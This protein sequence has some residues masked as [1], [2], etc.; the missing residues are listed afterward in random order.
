MDNFRVTRARE[1]LSITEFELLEIAK[2]TGFTSYNSF[3]KTF[4]NI[5]KQTPSQYRHEQRQL[6]LITKHEA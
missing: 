4:K 5:T 6:K 2:Q 1:M 3:Y